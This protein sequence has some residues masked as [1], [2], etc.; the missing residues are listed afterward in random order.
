MLKGRLLKGLL[1]AALTV[2]VVAISGW[3]GLS[4]CAPTPSYTPPP[5][6]APIAPIRYQNMAMT[7]NITYT[8]TPK[9]DEAAG[10]T[11]SMIESRLNDDGR[12]DGNS[13]HTANGEATNFYIYIT[14]NDSGY[15]GNDK[16]TAYGSLYGWGWNGQITSL[17]SGPYPYTNFEDMVNKFTDDAYNW[18]HTGWHRTGC[19]SQ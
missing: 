16:W 9:G 11:Q 3:M 5:C 7:Y 12:A 6:P 19:P 4:G 1:I 10:D 13:F 2:A 15:N 14:I 8:Y 17:S 18:I